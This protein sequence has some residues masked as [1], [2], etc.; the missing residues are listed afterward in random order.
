MNK[1]HHPTGLWRGLALFW[2]LVVTA[3][4]IHQ[5]QFWRSA[6]LDA[7]VMALLPHDARQPDV[8]AAS[9]LL[10]DTAARRIVVL[11]RAHDWPSSQRAAAMVR[12]SLAQTTLLRPATSN[13]AAQQTSLLDFYR[14]WRTHVLTPAQRQWLQTTTTDDLAQQALIQLYQPGGNGLSSWQSDPLGLV[15]QW[16]LSHAHETRV[17]IH[18]GV[19]SVQAQDGQEWV[20]L[21]YTT[22][23]AAFDL[24]GN[25]VLSNALAAAQA[26]V[27]QQIPDAQVHATGVPFFAEAAAEQANREANLIGWGSLAAVLL[28]VWLAF[29][30]IRPILL[31]VL[32]LTI[33]TAL[34]LS[35]T[36]LIWGRVHLLT[37]VFGASLVG[38]AEDYGIHYF[39]S[40]QQHHQEERWALLRG[41]LPGLSL[42]LLTSALAYLALGLAPFPG[43][44]Q[45]A[46][47]SAVGLLGAFLTVVCWF[48]WLEGS[49]IKASRFSDWIVASL[50][51][52]PHLPHGRRGM[53]LVVVLGI[54]LALGLGRIRI[55][56][57][58]RQLQG[59]PQQRISEQRLVGQILGLPSPAQFYLIRGATPDAVLAQEEA[60]KPALDRLV[61]ARQLMGYLAL[62]NWLPSAAQQQANA[63]LVLRVE[64]NVRDRISA[65][66]GETLPKLTA[67][68]QVL[69][70]AAWQASPAAPLVGSLWLGRLGSGYA[71]VILL[72]EPQS[73]ALP[74]FAA[75]A[76]H[77]QGVVWVDRTG[78]ISALLGR[79]RT[80]MG[81][82]LLAGCTAVAL[83]L[84]W[85]YGRQ[86]WRA[87]LPTILAGIGAV[88]IQGCL[89]EPFQL[90][91][92][93]ALLLLLGMGV[94]YGIFQLEHGQADAGVAW[95][96]IVL[97]A[98][99]T[100]LSFG[101]LALS[102]TPALHAFGL[103][104]LLGIGLVWLLTPLFRPHA[105]DQSAEAL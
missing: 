94:D 39:A 81:W 28:M 13:A 37:L 51:R 32:S 59:A 79:Y 95:L 9:R 34:G 18:D 31:V 12:H 70:L 27:Q 80:L 50:V 88:A 19:S 44:Q 26:Q 102:A 69:T 40:R 82:L 63:T 29:R 92:V 55:N 20:L 77:L 8:E 100:L 99:S 14:P 10:A 73:R 85:R 11:V 84:F 23:G 78:E 17:R 98:V 101:L 36:A 83:A 61:T 104:M 7:D 46:L 93:L 38:V 65:Q 5:V 41:L 67:N 2:L 33:G 89:G 68:P 76:V 75:A 91:N 21:D 87:L 43:L 35:V 4:V 45:M 97:G 86:S 96:A 71:S 64:N 30:S 74:Q 48:P 105:V 24:S 66:L 56:D 58:I 103:T 62:S 22:V 49:Q 57:D 3:L 16:W 47:F 90:F 25:A 60:L 53:L 54:G 6:Q 15:P 72:Q 1:P 42:A 52:L